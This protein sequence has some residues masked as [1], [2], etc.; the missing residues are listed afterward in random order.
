M[1]KQIKTRVLCA[2]FLSGVCLLMLT[3]CPGPGDRMRPDETAQVDLQGENVCFNVTEAQD[4]QPADMAINPRG[5]LSKNK[6]INFSPDLKVSDGKLC[7]PPSYYRFPD[8]GQFIVEYVLTSAKHDSE[9]R[10]FVVTLEINHG[11][12]YNVTPTESEIAL[13]YC[14]YVQDTSVAACQL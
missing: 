10:R 14:R 13:P 8:K 9:P 3:G 12:I 5:T 11:H 2:A 4:Y 1:V 7:I 6:N